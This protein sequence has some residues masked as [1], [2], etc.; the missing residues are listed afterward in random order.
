[1]SVSLSAQVPF[2]ATTYSVMMLSP[3]IATAR[4][5]CT[6]TCMYTN[7][8]YCDD[9]GKGSLHGG[10]SVCDLGTDCIDCGDRVEPGLWD[11][12]PPICTQA[13][14]KNGFCEDNGPN[15]MHESNQ[16][17]LPC[18]YGQDCGDCGERPATG[19]CNNDCMSAGDGEC[20]DGRSYGAQ[21]SYKLCAEGSDCDDC[22]MVPQGHYQDYVCRNWVPKCL[23]AHEVEWNE[24]LKS[25][26]CVGCVRP[27]AE[28]FKKERGCVIDSCSGGRIPASGGRVCIAPLPRP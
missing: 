7:D 21:Y 5:L 23:P 27:Y 4:I 25:N 10:A 24:D 9:G 11:A 2:L 28:S 19:W 12:T 16:H 26:Q 1:M 18:A 22:G 20:D 3:Q 6:E 17:L 14:V 8:G 13:C 15:N